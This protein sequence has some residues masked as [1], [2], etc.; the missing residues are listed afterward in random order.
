M[1]KILYCV[2]IF[3]ILSVCS[4][5][6][7]V[8]HTPCSCNIDAYS[9]IDITHLQPPKGGF[10]Q[11]GELNETTGVTYFFAGCQDRKFIPKDYNFVNPAIAPKS[12]SLIKCTSSV[13]MTN[14]TVK[15]NCKVI[16]MSNEI[17]FDLVPKMGDKDRVQY[18]ISYQNSE[19]NQ[20]PIIHL[21]CDTYNTTHLKISNRATDVLMLYSPFVCVQY[22]SHHQLSSGS[23]FCIMFFVAFFTYF[24]GGA[25]I[26]YFIRG[27]RGVEILP[28]FDFWTSMP[29][30]IKDGLAYLL[31]GCRPFTVSS[32]ETYDRI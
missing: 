4:A 27:A 2:L 6:V 12:A 25:L 32:A 18:Q 5:T 17:I 29:G 15:Q 7:C 28:N 9:F 10:F 26:M 31:T 3:S 11:D 13:I 21:A 20:N 1:A 16:G 22:I 19:R 8:E 14:Q 23:I 30:L 24:I